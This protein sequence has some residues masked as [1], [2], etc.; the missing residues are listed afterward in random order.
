MTIPFVITG[1]IDKDLAGK[2][3]IGFEASLRINRQDFGVQYSRM[4]DNGGLVVGNNVTIELIG[5]AVKQ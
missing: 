5:E 2:T 3:R 1:K 4:M